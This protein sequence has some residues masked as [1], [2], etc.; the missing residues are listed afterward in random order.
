MK[1]LLLLCFVLLSLGNRIAAQLKL[2]ALFADSM[3]LQRNTSAPVWGWAAPGQKVEVSGSWSDKVI[4][5]VA[6]NDGKWMLRLPTPGAGGP[7]TLRIKAGTEKRLQGVLI[8]EV[9]ICSGQSNMEMPVEGWTTDP[10]RNSA[11]EIAAANY[12]AIRLFTVE[13]DI[14]YAPREDV[15]GTWSACSPASVRTFSATAYFFGKELYNKLKVPVGLIHTSWGGTVAEAWTSEAGLRTMGDFNKELGTIDSIRENRAA[16]VEQDRRNDLKWQQA[17]NDDGAAYTTADGT[18]WKTMKLPVFWEDAGLPDI[19][20]VV[21][22]KHRVM[23]PREWAGKALRLDLGPIDD[24][25]VMYFNGVAVDSTTQGFTWAAERHYSIPG[26]L[27]KAGDNMITVKIIDDGGSGGMYGKAEQMV[28]YPAGGVAASGIKLNGEWQY[29]LAAVKPKPLLNTWPNQPSVLYN[30]M[31][32]P[33]VPFAIKGAIWYQGESNVGR[34]K[35]YTTLF[36]LMIGDWRR[37]WDQGNFPFYFVQIAPFKYWGETTQAAELRDAQRRTLSL[38]PHTGM[39]VTLDIGN[40][41]NIHPSDKPEVGK[42]L[43][44]WALGE[45]YK[46]NGTVYSG[47]LYKNFEVKEHKVVVSFTHTDSGLKAGSGALEGFELQGADGLWKPATAVVEG[48][49]VVVS[50]DAVLNPIGVRYAFYAASAGTLFNGSG[51]P[52]SSFTSAALK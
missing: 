22:F 2:P 50:S 8:G 34:A 37:K 46:M 21:W 4:R 15:K 39:A 35:Q 52:A 36:P 11:Q 23:I 6:G 38:S 29:K 9:W 10:V 27:V 13:K 41:D 12:P 45:T 14:A 5:A 31:I 49:T 18:G 44:L 40:T 30:A 47:P 51:L 1:R 20:G 17:V 19:D 42:R 33:L 48:N 24:R 16:I 3:V 7:Y 32:A 25:D 28:L 26:K 43:A